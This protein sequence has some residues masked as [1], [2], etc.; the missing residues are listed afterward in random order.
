MHFLSHS[1]H[2]RFSR[3]FADSKT[4]WGFD[5]SGKLSLASTSYHDQGSLARLIASVFLSKLC[6]ALASIFLS[7]HLITTT[8]S[9]G[10][11]FI[12]MNQIEGQ[13]T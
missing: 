3:W 6:L 11:W 12:M 4:C 1:K 7:I 9:L 5:G 10:A 13:R 8:F 2:S